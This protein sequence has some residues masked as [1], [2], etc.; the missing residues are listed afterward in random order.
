VD[1]ID[2]GTLEYSKNGGYQVG[3]FS[4]SMHF[5]WR[6]VPDRDKSHRKYTDPVGLVRSWS[7][8]RYMYK[9]LFSLWEMQCLLERAAVSI[10]MLR[11]K[12]YYL[13]T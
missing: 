4:W 2:A 10:L 11:V 9:G 6:D 12:L 8:C 7:M 13:D 1:A 5:T 3:G